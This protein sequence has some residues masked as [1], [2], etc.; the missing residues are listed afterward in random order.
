MKK[1][2]SLIFFSIIYVSSYA[3]QRL[4]DINDPIAD[5]DLSYTEGDGITRLT[6][7]LNTITNE[8]EGGGSENYTADISV[9]GLI[10]WKS[11]PDNSK[12]NIL[13][14]TALSKIGSDKP[15][16]LFAD[17]Y[18]GTNNFLKK[19]TE[20]NKWEKISFRLSY[21][22]NGKSGSTPRLNLYP[23]IEDNNAVSI[24]RILNVGTSAILKDSRKAIVSIKS[25]PTGTP[26]EITEMSILKESG[27]NQNSITIEKTE[28]GNSRYSYNGNLSLAFNT[29]F[30]IETL[31]AKYYV[32]CKGVLLG[33][34]SVPMNGIKTEVVFVPNPD[35]TILNRPPGYSILLSNGSNEYN[36]ENIETRGNGKLG[37]RF[38]NADYKNIRSTVSALGNNKYNIKLEGLSEIDSETSST[39]FYTNASKDVSAPLVISKKLPKV[40]NFK[41]NGVKGDSL[42]MS[43]KLGGI[44]EGTTPSISLTGD[45]GTIDIGGDIP[46][47]KTPDGNS[48]N[49]FIDRKISGVIAE[50]KIIRD[51]TINVNYGGH[52]LYNLTV[53]VFNQ[54][55]YNEKLAALEVETSKK[56]KDR[57]KSKVESL[58]KDILAIGEAVGNS[59]NDDE[60]SEAIDSLQTAKGDKVK[61]VMGDVGKWALI[62][63]KIILP[64]L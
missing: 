25:T 39:Y 57:A 23:P 62:A 6:I 5:I 50:D 46:V 45:Q 60:V 24:T 12:K 56:P 32:T 3:Q 40:T 42:L 36:D 35:L 26:F 34:S 16:V 38:L 19:P 17:L 15:F 63:G 54:K 8:Q 28:L 51:V 20:T 31:N 22:I 11:N 7:I 4:V 37:I 61:K 41:F 64:F 53:T 1:L 2:Y 30:D 9:Q 47:K 59:I 13:R 33:D 21:V 55:L 44:D 43:F 10:Q 29:P 52:V 27:G 58:V 48:F 14:E 18:D 49:V